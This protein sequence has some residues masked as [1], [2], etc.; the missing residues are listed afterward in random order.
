[1]VDVPD[2]VFDALPELREFD[3]PPNGTQCVSTA[4]DVLVRR[5]KA[6]LDGDMDEA[7]EIASKRFPTFEP[8]ERVFGSFSEVLELV[9][10][11]IPDLKP[12]SSP[13]FP[14]CVQYGF[15]S[16]AIAAEEQ[17]MVY[18]AAYRLMRWRDATEEERAV[19]TERPGVAVNDY[20]TAPS[21]VFMKGEPHSE[22]KLREGRYRII[23]SIDVVSQLAVRAFAGRFSRNVRN[24]F[25]SDVGSAIGIGFTD[26]CI[27]EF[28]EMYSRYVALYG[29]AVTFDVSGWDRSLPPELLQLG[30][31]V[32]AK[33][34]MSHR[35]EWT[36][37]MQVWSEL[38]ATCLYHLPD[39]SII[40]KEYEGMMA[41]GSYLTSTFNTVMRVLLASLCGNVNV[42]NGDDSIEFSP[43]VPAALA[44]Y[45]SMGFKLRELKM[46]RE[47]KFSFCSHTYY[48][49]ERGRWKASLDTWPKMV[50]AYF[51]KGCKPEARV[52]IMHEIRH[53]EEYARIADVVQNFTPVPS[54][55]E[56]E[57]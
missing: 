27:Q 13:G 39:G 44:K 45:K 15:N 41:S 35:D 23:N 55:G 28:G 46:E 4:L 8:D 12:T 42:A 32:V 2:G 6:R 9:R 22:R 52:S 26:E 14:L 54:A 51:R 24:A 33:L 38:M 19:W 47:D 43:D 18:V 40:R 37:I 29:P 57:Y 16:E 17:M 25:M 30:V 21:H 3:Y 49:D 34:C 53:N 36:G 20:I 56:N 7:V 5:S 10:S 11:K 48:R 31:R 50:Y 1:M